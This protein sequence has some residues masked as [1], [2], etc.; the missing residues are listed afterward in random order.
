MTP[1]EYAQLLARILEDIK[2]LSQD[3]NDLPSVNTLDGIYFLPATK[4]DQVVSAPVTLLAQPA[5][6]AAAK[7]NDAAALTKAIGEATA[8]IAT[9][10]HQATVDADAATERANTAAENAENV[11]A[12]VKSLKEAIVF[13]NVPQFVGGTTYTLETAIAA[14]EDKAGADNLAYMKL[15]VVLSYATADGWETKQFI[16]TSLDDISDLDKWT[17]FGKGGS[18][19]GFYDVTKLHPLSDGYYTKETAVAALADADISDEDKIGLIITL[20][21]SAGKWEEYRYTGTTVEGFLSPE[22]WVRWGG[23]DAIKKLTVT[24]GTQTQE[25]TPDEFGNVN[26]DIPI[27]EVDETIDE[28]STNPASNKAIAAEFKKLAEKY[29]AALR[30]NTIGSGNDVAYSLALLS[31]HGEVLSTSDTFTGGGGATSGTRVVLTRIS[32]NP[33]V[34]NGDEVKLTYSYDQVDTESGES[35]GNTGRSVI[36]VSRGA[37]TNT[38]EKDIAAGATDTIDVTKYMGV[39][40]NTVRVR[41]YAGEG[42]EQQVATITWT[43]NVVQL[44]L[45]S[46][47]NYASIINKG[48]TISVPFA[49]SG[50][51]TKTLRLYVNGV[52]VE[53]RSI[54]TSTANGSFSINTAGMAHGSHSVQL[55]CELELASGTIIKS[56]SI[57]FGIAVRESGRTAPIVAT[58]FDFTDGTVI[59]G[60]AQPYIQ[61]RQF[62]TYTLNY[63]VYNPKETP[64]PVQVYESNKVISSAQISFVQNTLTVRAMNPGQTQCKI[65]CEDMTYFFKLNVSQ[66]ELNLTEP[67]DN[68]QLKL[69]AEGRSN[70]DLDKNEWKYENITTEFSGVKWGGD[71][72]LNN[73]LRLKDG[74]KAVVGYQPLRQ[75]EQNVTNA[76]AFL[77]KFKVSEV[78]DDDAEVIRCIDSAGTGF[79]ITTQEARMVTKGNSSLSM[80][81]AA[82]E[83]YEVGF[84]SYPLATTNSSD[85]EKLNTEMLYLYIN[86]IASGGVQRG[87]SDSIYQ[88]TPQNI[89]LGADSGAMLD[90][91]L[92]RGYN[93]YLSDSQMLDCF[94]LDQDNVD[95]MIAKYNENAIIDGNGIVSVDSIPDDMR[96]VI[97]T[98]Q[99]ANGV[100]TVMQAAVNNDKNPKYDVDEILCIKRSE[101]NLNFKLVGGCIRLQGTSSLAYPIKNYRIYLNN[102]GKIDGTM[103]LGCDSQGVGGTE[104]PGGGKGKVKYSFR[105]PDSNGKIPAPVNCFCLKADFAE[106]SSSHNTGFARL[107]NDILKA[108]GFYTP[109]Q[110]YVDSSFENDVRTTIDGE[111]CLLFY[112]ETLDDTP[113]LVGKFN[114]NNDKS[115]EDVFGFLNIP[116]YHDANW[117]QEKFGGKN[118]TECWEFLNN[119]YPMGQYLDDDFDTIGEDGLPNWMKVFEARFPDNNDEYEDGVKKPENL[120]R[121]VKWVKATHNNPTKFKSE[122]S[123]YA[124]VDYM[125]A[126]FILTQIFGNV[127]QMVKNAMIAFFYDPDTDKV[128]AYYIFY[129]NDTLMGVRNDSRLIYLWDIN[130]QSIDTELSTADKTVYAYAGH[131]SVLWNNLESNCQTEIQAVYKRL[132]AVMSNEYIFNVFDNEQAGKYC[133]RLYNLDAQY[134]YVRPKTIGIEVNQ[135][136]VVSNVKYSYM[137]AMQGSREAHRR[138]WLTNRI[139]LF[140]AR[141]SAGQYSLTDITW[142]GNSAVGATVK[143]AFSRDF[144]VEFRREGTTMVHEAVKEGVLWSYA[145]EQTANIGTIFHLLG[146]IFMS[147]LDLSAW[148]GFTDVNIPNLPVLEELVMGMNGKTYALTELVIGNKLPMLRKLD[149]RN[150]TNIPYLDL[151]SCNRLEEVNAGGCTAM[152]VL[153]LAEGAPIS[154][155]TLPVNYQTLTLRSLA[156]ITRSGITFENAANITGL[157]VENC[158]K[159]DGFTL[160]EELFGLNGS[161]LKYVRI[162]GLDMVGDGSDLRR[163]YEAGLGGIDEQGN[164]VNN[165]CKLVGNYQLDRYLPDEEFARFKARFDELNIKQPEYTM[166]ESDNSVGDDENIS[167]LDNKT[168]Y[169][170]GNQ[171]VMSAHISAIFNKRHRVLAKVTKMPT[172]RKETIA[173]GIVDVNNTDGEMTYFPLHDENSNY[174][175]D[176]E[177]VDNCTGAKLDGTE[178]DWMMYEPFYWSKGINDYLNEKNYSCY[179]SLGKDNMPSVPA[180]TV[181]TLDDIKATNGGFLS[182]RKIT[183]GKPTLS[184]SYANDTTYSVCK[185]VVDGYKRV[186]F[187]SVPGVSLVGSVF[188]DDAGIVISSIIVPMLS[189]RFE[190][191]MYLITDVPTGAT[192]IH[193]SILNTAEFDKVV[194]SNSNRIEDMEPEWVANEEH[195]CAIVGSTAVGTKLRACI[196]GGTTTASMSWADFHYYSQQRGM[197]QIDAL[198]HFRI[199]NLFFAKYGRRDSQEA[200]G[201][202]QHSNVRITGGSASRGMQD[203]IGF[204]EAY[205][206]NPNITNSSPSDVTH[207]YAWYKGKD[208]YNNDIVTQVNNICC[209]GYEDIYGHKYDMM[210]GVDLPNTTGNVGKWRIWMPDGSVR[211][212]KG[213]TNSGHWITAVA[214]G[215]YMDVIPV[216]SVNGSSST[217]YSDM[218]YFSS[219]ANRVVFRSHY[220]AN[221]DGGV[222]YAAA[223]YDSSFAATYL[224]SRLAFRGK[225]VKAASVAAFKA[226]VALD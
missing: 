211:W 127:D 117:V 181:L 118:P 141:Y 28:N 36:T 215:K 206:I 201:A 31:E 6:D 111:P 38:I 35:T 8:E 165:A 125:C 205:A 166:L 144:Y 57:Y 10:A 151:S 168:G 78:M 121:W 129:D 106:S 43:V 218:F 63:A 74:G 5:I 221:A 69:S 143:A 37:T 153:T 110:K 180:A 216:G 100:A 40:S 157:W 163:W 226:L 112:R 193:F 213:M 88:A 44:T 156:N 155:L 179:S 171:Y 174:Y 101:P 152:S 18:G 21:V 203:T 94:I 70:N 187:P 47:F 2:A 173:G 225:I 77:I 147:K 122:L 81:M 154:K 90:V 178:G 132:R 120:M 189:N 92:M 128:L 46:S 150:Y 184:D 99:Q 103:Y 138:W 75:P 126:Y 136:G 54:T 11:S 45:T 190:A 113:V 61:T 220:N 191:G 134:K 102:S 169:K 145:Y 49:L 16:G 68:I 214:H 20:E 108:A 130:R 83:T 139:H 140:D 50:S 82:G 56:N 51:G 42:E 149:L 164:T 170:F 197:Q 175:S 52:D 204:D 146:G 114:F 95:E 80:K 104:I 195:L 22:A 142:K 210:D 123:N 67:T 96:Y 183:T 4:G 224:G 32:P 41:V 105:N 17:D 79:I 76:F 55:V 188:T 89:E 9:G 167:N 65:V 208:E 48:D 186:R 222:A 177:K 200:C 84:V 172:S 119:D 14:V 12:D 109:A 7:A 124:D 217:N 71:G 160:F 91:Y 19:S 3:V 66:T 62:N 87:T 192:Q 64:T 58:R 107:A 24:K 30:L 158:E 209:M 73:A 162:T 135:N 133:E 196:T 131:D 199:A 98:G 176:A 219:S 137:E 29:G 194:L 223:Y 198:M 72:W 159:L 115:T 59:L 34:K 13:I 15:G 25:L 185:V 39:G 53:D 93:S 182:G 27:I 202:G 207:Q 60:G 148:G 86:G 97:V 116:G 26:L 23:G 212:V 33:T 85:H 1:E 161:S